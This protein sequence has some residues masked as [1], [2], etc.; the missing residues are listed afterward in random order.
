MEAD[1]PGIWRFPD[2]LVAGGDGDDLGLLDRLAVR[3]VDCLGGD[4]N[5]VRKTPR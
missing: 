4:I 5:N 3:V 1:E 2:R